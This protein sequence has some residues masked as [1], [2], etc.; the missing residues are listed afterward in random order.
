M[1]TSG[2]LGSS[3]HAQKELE[4][5]VSRTGR[6]WML[7]NHCRSVSTSDTIAMG[8]R[9]MLHSCAAAQRAPR[10]HLQTLPGARPAPNW[11]PSRPSAAVLPHPGSGN[12]PPGPLPLVLSPSSRLVTPCR[13]SAAVLAL[14]NTAQLLST[15][16]AC[17]RASSAALQCILLMCRDDTT[18]LCLGA[19]QT[20]V[21]CQQLLDCPAGAG[22]GP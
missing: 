21:Q 17:M 15:R 11:P 3:V 22:V 8:T 20:A 18:A 13:P 12:P 16:H 4:R 19:L 14:R 6:P 7:L 5:S 1:R 10:R 9:K 2:F